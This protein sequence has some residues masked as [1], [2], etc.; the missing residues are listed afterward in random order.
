VTTAELIRIA[1]D[2]RLMDL[3]TSM[4]GRVEKYDASNQRA[5]I[6][7]Q[8][9]RAVP[10]GEGGYVIEQLPVLPNVEVAFPRGGGFFCSFPIQKGDFVLLVFTERPI[11][12][13]LQKG[14]AC[15]PGDRRVHPLAGA[16]ALAGV[17]PT[18]SA[19][20]SA[21]GSNLRIGKDGTG[22]AQIEIT[23]AEGRLG[24]GATKEIAR[25]G[26]PINLGACF[27]TMGSGFVTGVTINGTP[28]PV[29]SDPAPDRGTVNGGSTKWK[30][31]D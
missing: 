7:P 15:D 4:P 8:Y 14:E 18:K 2:A 5:D 3:H 10:D 1:L 27:V 12:N 23:D 11:G 17:Y 31:V 30:A 29:G 26:D 25:K 13:W 24:I 9:K 16:V 19:L 28:L 21:S 6:L 20:E 22:D